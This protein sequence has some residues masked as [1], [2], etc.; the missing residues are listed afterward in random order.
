MAVVSVGLKYMARPAILYM[1]FG[2]PGAGK[3]TTARIISQL[4]GA[5]RLSSDQYRA[6]KYTTPTFTPKEH[7]EVYRDLDTMCRQLLSQGKDVI[8]DANL[9]RRI[10]RQEKYE[11]CQQTNA[12]PKLLW[13]Q[14]PKEIAKT[15]ATENGEI[16]PHRP[17]G[18]LDVAV[19]DRLAQEIETPTEDES[20][21]V[22][23][24]T[25]IT[26]EYIR[27]LLQLQS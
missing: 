12:K 5:V 23:D 13:V 20:Y 27:T 11:I 3:T 18:N 1:M 17:F 21:I 10:H 8:Y 2:Y 6:E 15:R 24:G 14:T 4:T 7:D 9:N 26:T 22:V 16:D 19:F 25:K